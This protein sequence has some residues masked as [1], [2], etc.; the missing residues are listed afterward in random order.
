MSTGRRS[1]RL[2]Q[3]LVETACFSSKSDRQAQLLKARAN[4]EQKGMT[5]A[6]LSVTIGD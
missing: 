5:T 2:P 6:M 4:K 3:I 1:L